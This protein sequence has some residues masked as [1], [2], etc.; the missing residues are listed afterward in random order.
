MDDPG[1]RPAV[2]DERRRDRPARIAGRRRR[3]CR[4]S[5]RR[6][7]ARGGRAAPTSSAV[8]SESQPA[9]GKASP[10]R[11][12]RSASAARSA[13]VT[14]EPPALDFTA[15]DV[16]APGRNQASATSP[17]S[18]AAAARRSRAA[19]ASRSGSTLKGF[20][21]LARRMRRR[22]QRSRSARAIVMS[23]RNWAPR[24][25]RPEQGARRSP[26]PRL[27]PRSVLDCL[28]DFTEQPP[29]NGVATRHSASPRARRRRS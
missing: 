8:S 12:L 25:Y 2:D 3:A 20:V 17:A 21:Q 11:R 6:R 19:S 15:A 9:S 22:L 14:G 29:W 13:S 5:D 4:R 16:L 24:L 7:S 28:G 26:P 27:G 18:R 1:D 23:R 10:S